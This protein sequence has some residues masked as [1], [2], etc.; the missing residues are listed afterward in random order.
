MPL[1]SGGARSGLPRPIRTASSARVHGLALLLLATGV[2]CAGG[3]ASATPTPEASPTELPGPAALSSPAALASPPAID[4]TPSPVPG[5]PTSIA[6]PPDG[7]TAA[8]AAGTAASPG[9]TGGAVPRGTERVRVAN[10]EGQGANLR[11]EPSA[12][13]AR[14]KTAREG[15]ELDVVGPNREVDGRTWRNVRD[16]ADGAS[17]WIVAELLATLPPGA[18]AASPAPAAAS[19]APAGAAAP[20]GPTR[21]IGDAD[22]TYLAQ[23]Q[24]EIDALGRGIGAINQQVEAATARPAAIEDQPWRAT[25]EAAA[26]SLSDAERR[27]RAARPGPGTGEVHERALRAADRAEEAARLLTDAVQSRDARRVGAV[28]TV[29]LRVLS[30]I[31]AMNSALVQLQ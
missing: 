22:R 30:E 3:G 5:P 10:S 25:S 19:P 13:A 1:L 23:L 20:A 27:I 26:G 24:P 15:T 7:G 9:P 29:L 6:G 18:A 8:P 28:R 12:S 4:G 14:V 11:A 2:A 16:P 31:N 21:Q 17:G